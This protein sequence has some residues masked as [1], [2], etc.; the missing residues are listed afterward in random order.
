MNDPY[1]DF[2]LQYLAHTS[3]VNPGKDVC[4]DYF[5]S[6]Y[7]NRNQD[8]LEFGTYYMEHK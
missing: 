7:E 1:F 6:T 8:K 4:A 2:L 3:P 5:S